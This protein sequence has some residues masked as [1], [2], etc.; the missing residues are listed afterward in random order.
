M[1]SRF[2]VSYQ[3][4][5]GPKQGDYI[6]A[7][8][9][10]ESGSAVAVPWFNAKHI[11]QYAVYVVTEIPQSSGGVSQDGEGYLPTAPT[12][13]L[14]FLQSHNKPEQAQDHVHRVTMVMSAAKMA[15]EQTS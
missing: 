9:E 5:N 11:L 7:P 10:M 1:T 4:L 3:C 8:G 6:D 13:G 14:M 12:L 15:A 2:Q